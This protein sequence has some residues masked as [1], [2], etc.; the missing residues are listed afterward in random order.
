MPRRMHE[1][2]ARAMA[3]EGFHVVTVDL[4]VGVHKDG[5]DVW[6]D[7]EGAELHPHTSYCV[8]GNT[9]YWGSVLYRLRRE[10]FGEI[11]HLDGVSRPHFFGGVATVVA[12]LLL[13]AMP[14]R[15]RTMKAIDALDFLLVID[16]SGVLGQVKH[17]LN[18]T[19]FSSFLLQAQ[20][21]KAQILGLA[22]AGTPDLSI[23][24]SWRVKNVMSFSVI[25]EPPPPPSFLTLLTL[26]P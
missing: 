22:N 20:N 21:S 4:P 2:L 23:V 5:Y 25:L 8:G 14:D 15:D 11:Q 19:D 24:A 26:T 6:R 7:R 1:P 16:E 17:P 9:K 13:Q 18:A 12:K 10:D 3:A